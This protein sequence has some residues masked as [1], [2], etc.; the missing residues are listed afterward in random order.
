MA[1]GTFNATIS[2]ISVEMLIP[3]INLKKSCPSAEDTGH[4]SW[5]DLSFN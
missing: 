3:Y 4:D 5:M 2:R 1:E